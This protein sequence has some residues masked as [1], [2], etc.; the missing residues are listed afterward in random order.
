MGKWK[1]FL[2]STLTAWE[3]CPQPRQPVGLGVG[4]R[5]L[6]HHL[7]APILPISSLANTLSLLQKICKGGAYYLLGRTGKKYQKKIS[8][9]SKYEQ[10]SHRVCWTIFL[11]AP[12]QSTLKQVFVFPKTV[13]KCSPPPY[14]TW[15]IFWYLLHGK[16]VASTTTVNILLENLDE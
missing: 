9:F 11:W 6:N 10:K 1:C 15:T 2:A 16:A 4:E 8:R 7:G 12:L 5:D 13:Q 14:Q 3:W